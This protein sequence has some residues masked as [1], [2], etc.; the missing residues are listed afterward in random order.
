VHKFRAIK[1]DIV[2]SDVCG[3]VVRAL[4]HAKLLT[5]RIL[6]WYL[7]IWNIFAPLNEDLWNNF[8]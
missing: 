1:C 5:P 4:L 2:A 6:R 7:D 3:S 8:K